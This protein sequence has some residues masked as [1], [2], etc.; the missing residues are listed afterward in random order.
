MNWE[1]EKVGNR[2]LAI[3]KKMQTASRVNFFIK[4]DFVLLMDKDKIVF[5]IFVFVPA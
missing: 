1:K 4:G 3:S 2:Q 5:I